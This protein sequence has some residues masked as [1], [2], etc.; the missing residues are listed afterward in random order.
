M[1]GQALRAVLRMPR[2]QLVSAVVVQSCGEGKGDEW[3][4]AMG[5]AT[6][7]AT[8]WPAV[9]PA[10]PRIVGHDATT[11][12][13]T[14]ASTVYTAAV[15]LLYCCCNAALPRLRTVLQHVH[16]C[17]RSGAL[18]LLLHCYYC[19]AAVAVAMHPTCQP[20]QRWTTG[21]RVHGRPPQHDADDKAGASV[22]RVSQM[23]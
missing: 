18:L 4:G 16:W 21:C 8:A 14:T 20:W 1:G 2:E 12:F 11:L 10:A 9:W 3:V 6:A 13:S 23:A 5:D 22:C 15:L 7:T 17:R 19:A